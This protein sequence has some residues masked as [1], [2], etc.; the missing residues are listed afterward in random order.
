MR[1]LYHYLRQML[2]EYLWLKHCTTYS[3]YKYASY[4]DKKK[5]LLEGGG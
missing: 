4:H 1:I 2:V 5:K 3:A